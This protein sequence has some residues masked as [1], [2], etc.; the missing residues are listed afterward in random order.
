MRRLIFFKL[1]AVATTSKSW[2]IFPLIALNMLSLLIYVLRV[3]LESKTG[4]V[5][6]V[7]H[8]DA[9]DIAAATTSS[10]FTIQVNELHELFTIG[11]WHGVN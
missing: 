8:P 11:T 9:P 10:I 1:S 2:L 3:A 7:A 4:C 6:F 5:L